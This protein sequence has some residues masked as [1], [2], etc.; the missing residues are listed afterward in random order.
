MK[1]TMRW[2]VNWLLAAV[3]AVSAVSAAGCGKKTRDDDQYLEILV[4]D[5]G[6]GVDWVQPMIDGFKQQA[7]VQDKYPDLDIGY[8]STTVRSLPLDEVMSG[9][10]TYDLMFSTQTIRS[11]ISFNGESSSPHFAELSDVYNDKVPGED[12]D[13]SAKMIDHYYDA[14]ETTSFDNAGYFEVPWVA[15]VTG[16]LYNKTQFDALGITTLPR[17]TDEL[18]ELAEFIKG[19]GKVPFIFTTQ[20]VYWATTMFRVWWAQY[21]GLRNYDLF[22]Q[23][24][25]ETDD[26]VLRDSNAVIA[27]IGRRRSLETLYNLIG[28]KEG[29]S[30]PFNYEFI[31]S[32]SFTQVQTKFILGGGLM[33]PNGDWLDSEMS[34]ETAGSDEFDTVSIMKPPVISSIVETLEDKNMSPDTLEKVIDAV[35]RGDTEY[36]GV[37]DNDFDRIREARNMNPFINEHVAFVPAYASA[38]ELAKDFLRF[39]ATDEAIKIFAQATGGATM[40]FEYDFETQAPDVYAGFTQ[41]HKDKYK[42][43][44]DAVNLPNETTYATGY[45]GGLEPLSETRKRLE[46]LF[47]AQSSNDRKSAQQVYDDEI[48]YWNQSRWEAMRLAAGI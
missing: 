41:L 46:A 12:V 18:Y 9:A 47:C 36:A 6:Y 28:V 20:Q 45:F 8:R 48:A 7:W 22:Y 33:S 16:L 21:E 29:T 13:F 40:P 31:N 19:E 2:I 43:F 39:M 32:E 35:D 34:S 26:G 3:L 25:V 5:F 42:L 23:G 10:S 44:A 11:N 37:S 38:K 24:F 30:N 27:Q 4:S 1:K 14:A 17:T 15:G